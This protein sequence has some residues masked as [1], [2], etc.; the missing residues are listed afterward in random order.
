MEIVKNLNF[1][2]KNFAEI[3]KSYFQYNEAST[4]DKQDASSVEARDVRDKILIYTDDFA[5]VLRDVFHVTDSA[6]ELQKYNAYMEIMIEDKRVE[7]RE[8][9]PFHQACLLELTHIYH[10]K[11]FQVSLVNRLSRKNL[12]G[13]CEVITLKP[14]DLFAKRAL[15]GIPVV[16][17]SDESEKGKI[18]ALMNYLIHFK[19]YYNERE[20]IEKSLLTSKRSLDD[21]ISGLL[22]EYDSVLGL[23][24]VN[25][26]IATSHQ[27]TKS[28]VTKYK[29][30]II[31]EFHQYALPILEA[32][33]VKEAFANNF[34]LVDIYFSKEREL[35]ESLYVIF[36][37]NIIPEMNR[38]SEEERTGVQILI[39]SLQHYAD[40]IDNAL[41]ET[42]FDF[43]DAVLN[44]IES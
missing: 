21:H 19:N 22:D 32:L 43:K 10:L 13:V 6:V 33:M 31:Q 40:K 18:S 11:H 9:D 3:Y 35:Q 16:N 41:K 8:V 14:L 7:N 34:Q 20:Y 23:E 17:F 4:E 25:Q 38:N 12:N 1:Q 5:T 29:K 15:K 2:E 39:Q 37:E 42:V 44:A 28:Q 36:D 24:V 27:I 26:M 30:R